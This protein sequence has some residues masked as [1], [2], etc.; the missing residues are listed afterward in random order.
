MNS[1]I[2]IIPNF[3]PEFER[4]VQDFNEAFELTFDTAGKFMR[5]SVPRMAHL[6]RAR[7]RADLAERLEA[8]LGNGGTTHMQKAA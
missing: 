7:G 8:T 6:A 2:L 3:S 4:A 1:S 5:E